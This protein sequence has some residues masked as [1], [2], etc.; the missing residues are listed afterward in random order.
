M[1]QEEEN[2]ETETLKTER[3]KTPIIF[4][5]N[6]QYLQKLSSQI[7]DWFKSLSP[8][9]KVT[10]LIGG[11][12]L[13]GSLINSLLQ[14]VISGLSIAILGLVVYFLY[15]YLIVNQEGNQK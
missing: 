8:I 9:G 13:G 14:V 12:I 2:Q 4:E 5:E 10:V 7:K 15:K 11:L 3:I 1:K 6:L